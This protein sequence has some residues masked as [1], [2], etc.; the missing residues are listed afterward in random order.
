MAP[1]LPDR[2]NCAQLADDSAVLER[3]Y[4][5]GE[6]PRLRDLLA[7][8]QGSVRAKFEFAK[9]HAARP[10]ATVS[11][12]ASPHLVC[13]RCLQVFAYG[14]AGSSEVEFSDGEAAADSQGEAYAMQEGS[15]SLRDVAEEEL[16][17]ALPIV[18]MHASADCVRSTA[19]AAD[20]P[21]DRTRPFAGLQDLLKKT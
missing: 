18:A 7:D 11:V 10:L 9:A 5:L 13:Q 15:I 3:E 4:P 2:V 17:L 8:S 14:A 12:I 6:M 1:G 16:L 21:S 19:Y 20:L